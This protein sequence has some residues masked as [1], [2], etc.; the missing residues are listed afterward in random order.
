MYFGEAVGSDHR[1]N[2]VWT[3][4][5]HSQLVRGAATSRSRAGG[6]GFVVPHPGRN[7]DHKVEGSG[8]KS[9]KMAFPGHGDNRVV[10]R[11]GYVCIP[12]WH[13]VVGFWRTT[14]RAVHDAG[15]FRGTFS[16]A[17]AD[18]AH[19]GSACAGDV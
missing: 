7:E 16:V 19:R 15:F 8:G 10:R 9:R 13:R 17:G 11:H 12:D 3:S 14:G 5:K 4:P 6:I 1:H 18:G 2:E